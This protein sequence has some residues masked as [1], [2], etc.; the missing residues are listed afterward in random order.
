MWI[1]GR[2]TAERRPTPV[3]RQELVRLL[4]RVIDVL[5]EAE[6]EIAARDREIARLRARVAAAE[7][8]AAAAE[9]SVDV[10]RCG[11]VPLHPRPGPDPLPVRAAGAP[12]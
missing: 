1:F 11:V 3:P 10:V 2:D 9:A 12:R 4:G 8:R 6:E 5:R 7:E